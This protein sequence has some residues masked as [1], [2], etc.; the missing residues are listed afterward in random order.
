MNWVNKTAIEQCKALRT[1]QITSSELL[2]ITITHSE[3]LI[4]H[5]NPFALKL[6]DRARQAAEKADRLLAKNKG[7]SL[8]GLPITI[9]DS[10]WLAGVKCANG[11]HTLEHFVPD[12]TSS[13]VKRLEDAGAVIFAKTTCPEFC[14]NGIT[15]S[16][17]YGRTSNPWN[18]SKTPGGSSGGAAAAVATGM[19]SLSLGGDGGGSIRI[20]A[21][22]CGITGFKP[23]F[24]NVP[25]GPGFKTWESII[26]YGPMARTVADTK[27]M[28]SVLAG[29]TLPEQQDTAKPAKLIASEN[30]G[31]AP[32]DHDV[33]NAFNKT[34]AIIEQA[35]HPIVH[36]HPGLHSSVVTWAVTATYDMWE[37]KQ[38]EIHPEN[39]IGSTARAFIEFGSEFTESDFEDAQEH[40]TKVHDAYMDMFKRN[41][42]AILLTPTLGC[43]AFDHGTIHP[44]KIGSTEITFPWLDWAGFL[45]DGNLAGLPACSIPMGVGDEGMPLSLQIVGAPGNDEEVLNVAHMIEQL[46]QWQH[47]SFSPAH[48][49]ANNSSMHPRETPAIEQLQEIHVNPPVSTPVF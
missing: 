34:L 23:S 26:A 7:G 11:S 6:Y 30:L 32:V 20:P 1:G 17:L 5:I 25:R 19:G 48:Y 49:S 33:Q 24:G 43:E 22:F 27:L 40:R 41:R 15:E 45:Y 31:F 8:T 47:P 16:E 14:V 42:S 18:I 39:N 13:A 2:E 28:Y 46:I 12:E 29:T 37:H 4:P 21:A 38:S 9:K 3:S 35:G 10:N 36:D 44:L